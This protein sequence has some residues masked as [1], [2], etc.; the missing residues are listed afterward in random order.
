MI[1]TSCN[2]P[3]LAL[4]ICFQHQLLF[5]REKY[6]SGTRGPFFST[7]RLNPAFAKTINVAPIKEIQV[8]SFYQPQKSTVSKKFNGVFNDPVKWPQNQHLFLSRS[9]PLYFSLSLYVSPSLSLSI[10]L[11]LSPLFSRI[12][13]VLQNKIV[14]GFFYFVFDTK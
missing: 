6:R 14:C 9:L 4:G 3:P 5:R 1:K 8:V 10:F 12:A 7:K 11:S 13:R 2:L